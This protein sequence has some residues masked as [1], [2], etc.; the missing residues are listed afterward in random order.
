[1]YVCMCCVW[2][3]FLH[4]LCLRVLCSFSCLHF[5]SSVVVEISSVPSFSP[6]V[7]C[8]IFSSSRQFPN[9]N[10]PW[11]T[12]EKEEEKKKRGKLNFYFV[13]WCW[14]LL[15]GSLLTHLL[16]LSLHSITYLHLLVLCHNLLV[17]RFTKRLNTINLN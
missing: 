7:S 15:R 1:M 13:G 3:F 12:F 2:E 16:L 11:P 10:S 5:L 6:S 9:S 8:T 4:F 14:A 17:A